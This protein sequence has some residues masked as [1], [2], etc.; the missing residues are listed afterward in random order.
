MID[1]DAAVQ[2]VRLMGAGLVAIDGLPVSGKS[3]LA[4]RLE[5]ELGASVLYL[6]DF[7]RPESEWR[8]GAQP[9][10]PFAYFRYDDFMAAV[11]DLAAG[12][13]ARYRRFDWA[14]GRVSEDWHTVPSEGLCVVEGASALHPELTPL[15]DLRLW[16]QS[17]AA[18]TLSAALTRGVGDWE[19]AW[20][21]LFMPSV[22]L[23]MASDPRQR[24]DYCVAGRGAGAHQP[25]L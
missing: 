8:S 25:F 12:R 10:F 21:D 22:A 18:T 19:Q 5:D 14:R 1:F 11:R 13:P 24:A 9:C 16:V 17:D 20:K 4:Q 6:D 15:Y 23:Y 3:T 2:Q 7:V